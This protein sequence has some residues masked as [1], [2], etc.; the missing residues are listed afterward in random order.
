MQS[1]VRGQRPLGVREMSSVE[2]LKSMFQAAVDAALPSICVP[3][4]LPPKPKGRTVI[5]GAG[6]ASGAMAWS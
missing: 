2:L 1:S 3:R 5:I 6:K 4:H